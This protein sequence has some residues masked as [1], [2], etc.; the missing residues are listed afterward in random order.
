MTTEYVAVLDV[1]SM[2][3]YGRA[4]SYGIVVGD[5]KGNILKETYKYSENDYELA[6]EEANEL[7]RHNDI[8]WIETNVKPYVHK[9]IEYT[10][11]QL[12]KDFHEDWIWLKQKHPGILLFA[13]APVPV[14]S[15]FLKE[16]VECHVP[17][18]KVFDFSPYPFLDVASF[19]RAHKLP[20]YFDR[21]SNELP[22]H[23][24]LMDA[25]QSYRG[26]IEVYSLINK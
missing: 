17:A 4:F 8:D 1:E 14:E 16:V 11:N 25:R 9:Y 26:L 15:N 12:T 13:D 20:D 3:L 21:L 6:F 7:K 5:I 23:H 24:P 22:V 10:S 19:R 2:G 18:T